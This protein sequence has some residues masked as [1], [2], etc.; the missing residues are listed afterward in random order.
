MKSMPSSQLRRQSAPPHD[1][2]ASPQVTAASPPLGFWILARDSLVLQINGDIL[3]FV[4]YSFIGFFKM[5]SR[6][7]GIK[8]LLYSIA[9]AFGKVDKEIV[10]IDGGL[11]AQIIGYM[12][13]LSAK[14]D[15]PHCRCDISFFLKPKAHPMFA[16]DVTFRNWHLGYYGV[17]IESLKKTDPAKYWFSSN[18]HDQGRQLR[19][20]LKET[21]WNINW[22]EVFPI[23]NETK[24]ELAELGLGVESIYTVIHVR[25]GDFLKFSS[26]VINDDSLL[27]LLDIIKPFATKRIILVS[28]DMLDKVLQ[29]NINKILS[30]REIEYLA[31]GDELFIH[32]IMRNAN[33]LITANS[34]FSLSAALLQKKGGIVILPKQFFGEDFSL[35]NEAINSLSRWM[36]LTE[37][38]R[39]L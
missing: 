10:R 39:E 26:W 11:G 6:R 5:V 18:L 25:K 3:K 8:Y 1:K 24:L 33:V 9:D 22:Q 29:M 34:M 30:D 4:S 20:F 38:S 31:G 16:A 27:S 13:Y 28:D 19:R 37:R 36:I 2:E 32:A 14:K 23:A 35:H 21:I 7:L 15:N 17:T 12:Q